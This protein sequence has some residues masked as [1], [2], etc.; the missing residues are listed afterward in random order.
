MGDIYEAPTVAGLVAALDAMTTPQGVLNRDVGIVPRKT[1]HL[2]Q[3]AATV[4]LR[5]LGALRWLVWIAIGN[6]CAAALLGFDWLPQAPWWLIALG[7]LLLITP[8]GRMALSALGARVILRGVTPGHHP[9]GGK[10]HLKV[11]LAEHL[12]DALGA[13]NLAGAPFIKT[14][15]RALGARVAKDVDLHSL[16]PITGMLDLGP[17]AS[18]EPEVDLRGHWID[19]ASF[20]LG[21]IRVRAGALVGARSTLLPGADVGK[22]AEIAPGS[23]VFGVVPKDESWS[24]APAVPSGTARGPWTDEAPAGNAAWK[25]AYALTGVIAS[26]LPILAA[27]A[28]LAVLVPVVSDA[29]SIGALLGR[30]LL[31]LP[32]AATVGFITLA[33]LVLVMTRLL[34]LGLHEGGHPVHSRQAWQAWSTLRLLDEAR[35]WLFPIYSSTITPVWLRALGARIGPDVEASTVLLIPRFTDVRAGAFLADD[36]LVASYASAA[37]G[38]GSPMHASAAAPSSATRAWPRRDAR[39]PR[40]AWSPCSRPRHSAPRPSRARVGSA[41]RRSG[42]VARVPTLTPPAPPLRPSNS[43]SLARSSRPAG[44]SRC[45][46]TWLSWPCRWR[47]WSGCGS[48]PGGCRSSSA[49]WSSSRPGPW[50]LR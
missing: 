6:A 49:G 38:S 2:A 30:G 50:R 36:T 33:L 1:Q 15:A 23:A 47:R 28:G 48:R 37:V 46:S 22:N 42:C 8:P 29:T 18:I 34:G 11:W 45:G 39:C 14:Y 43:A 10:V 35:T 24:G 7:W 12:E 4:L 5:S 13:T 17:G 16:P 40:R 3:A 44:R 32:V 26:T 19:G 31:W 21:P 20:I 25:A 41:R 9:R 27:L